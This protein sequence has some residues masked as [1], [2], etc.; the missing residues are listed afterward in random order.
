MAP[1]GESV[2]AWLDIFQ[3]VKTWI[4]CE[5]WRYCVKNQHGVQRDWINLAWKWISGNFLAWFVWKIC[6]KAWFRA[7]LGGPRKKII[8]ARACPDVW[9]PQKAFPGLRPWT[10]PGGLTVPPTPSCCKLAMLPTEAL[11]VVLALLTF[12]IRQVLIC[13]RQS[14]CGRPEPLLLA[15]FSPRGDLGLKLQTLLLT[16]GVRIQISCLKKRSSGQN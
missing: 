8:S 7:P 9:L 5:N 15:N 12:E 13:I 4:G 14:L 10:P 2:M 3:G 11:L 16:E 1:K 6:V